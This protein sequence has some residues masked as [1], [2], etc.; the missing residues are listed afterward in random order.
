MHQFPS[1]ILGLVKNLVTRN[2]NVSN[3]E[4]HVEKELNHLLMV[5]MINDYDNKKIN[6]SIKNARRDPHTK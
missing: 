3:Y 2:I 6:K 4:E 5:F 1:Q